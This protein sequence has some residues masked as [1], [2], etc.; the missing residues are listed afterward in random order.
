MKSI[1]IGEYGGLDRLHFT[2][3]QMPRAGDNEVIVKVKACGVNHLDIWIRKGARP[4]KG[5]PHIMGSEISGFVAEPGG[6]FKEG[7]RVAVFPWLYCGRCINCANGNENLCVKPGTIGRTTN[8][9]YAEFAS[10]PLQNLARLPDNVSCTDAA[11]VIL[12]GT[13]ALRMIRKAGVK[14][15]DTVLVLAAGSGVGSS[16]VQLCRISGANVIA[17]AGS[18]E[19]LER[20]RAIGAEHAINYT[21]GS[22][23]EKVMDLTGG[24][25]A[26]AVIEQV[27][28][29][30][31][32]D[33]L[34][35]LKT[36]GTIVTCGATSG[37][38]VGLDILDIFSRQLRIIGSSSGMMADMK[39]VLDHV[40]N[41]AF[42]PLVS[43]T[44]PLEKAADA[45]RLMESRN[46][47]GKIILLP[48]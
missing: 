13:T 23:K 48:H 8:G 41:G 45:H 6:A 2:R 47:F 21:E 38:S 31:W 28:K 32:Q 26:D 14:K 29:D 7:D 17:A 22:M 33:S 15:G 16:A 4:C 27:G 44:F 40:A 35:C 5:F 30:T 19:K 1:V 34:S 12:A 20:A 9:G 10:V 42:K 39:D 46:F 3:S 11:A 18:D 25:G 43:K 36:G 37:S 24:D